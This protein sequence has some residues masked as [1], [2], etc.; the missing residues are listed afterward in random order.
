MVLLTF[1]IVSIAAM[2]FPFKRK[3][4]FDA[5]PSIVRSR[6]GGIPVISILGAVAAFFS[7]Y[8]AYYALTTSVMGPLNEGSYG[9]IAGVFLL[10]VIIYHVARAY[11]LSKDG[12]D[13]GLLIK[14][15]PPE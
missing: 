5:S 6:V 7:L 3:E 4:I 2:I 8:A 1:V 10:G 13:L 15:I 12:I 14:Q 11:R 9:L